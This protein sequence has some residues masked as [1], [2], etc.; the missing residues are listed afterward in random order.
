MKGIWSAIGRLAVVAAL[1][2]GI[3]VPAIRA[4]VP[5]GFSYQGIL[6]DNGTPITSGNVTMV[7]VLMDVN[8]APLYTET[9]QNV[10]VTNGIFNVVI[11]GT[12][13]P[14]PSTMTFDEQYL[15]QVEVE[16]SNG[17][18]TFPPTPLW[19]APFALN[20]GTVGGI[21]ASLVPT[22][23]KLFPV[24]IGSGY[25]GT[26]R[27]DPAFLPPGAIGS[28]LAIGGGTMFGNIAMG[29]NSITGANGISASVFTGGTGSFTTLSASSGINLT[30][31]TLSTGGTARLDNSGN[32]TNITSLH[33]TGPI[34]GAT[35]ISSSGNITFSSLGNGVVH[36]TGGTGLLAST[37]VVNA[38]IANGTIDLTAKVT[39]VL[40]V[41]NGG[42]GVSKVSGNVVFASPANGSVGPPAFR[43]LVPADLPS[44]SGLYLPTAGGTMTGSI[45]MTGN[46]ISGAGTITGTTVNANAFNGGSGS[47]TT[48]VS[49]S[50]T[51]LGPTS[52][53]SIN[54]T[55]IGLNQP[56]AADFTSIGATTLGTGAFTTLFATSAVSGGTVLGVTNS[57][58]G[59]G[60]ST[61]TGAAI[62]VTGSG[63]GNTYTGI[64]LN[65]S[66][67]A[68][69]A[70]D[71]VGTSANWRVTSAGAGT[72][73]SMSLATPL[74]VS[75][76][77]T[78]VTSTSQNFVFAGP[79]TGNGAPTWR[80]L[81]VGDLPSLNGT[82]LPISGGTM[83]GPINMSGNAITNGGPIT[84]TAITGTTVTGGS[85]AATNTTNQ[86]V[87]GTAKTITISS[88]SPSAS[89]TYTLPDAGS[90]ASFILS[91][92]P[93]GQTIGGG[94][95][96]NGGLTLGTPLAV[97]QGGTGLTSTSQNFVFAGPMS[98]SGAPTWRALTA[99]DLPNLS[100]SYLPI[101]G[102]TM[103]GAINM[104]T[105]N[106]TNA[107]TI[108]G[109]AITGTSI[110]GTSFNGGSGSFTT[111][112]ATNTTN[113]LV[114]G[115]TK[116][117]TISSTTPS[118]SET[119]TLP[120]AGGAASFILSTSPASQT[121]GGGLTVNGGLTLG[122]PL[123]VAQGGTGLTSTSQNFVFAGP[124]TGSGAP[125]WR[126]LTAGDLPNLS[127]SY[128]PIS[129]GTMA[130]AINMG[131]NNI[132]NAGTIT[133][134]A[135]TGTSITGTS[136][137]G[138]TGSF[139]TLAATNTT[140]QLV[141]GTAKTITISSTTPLAS[142]TYTLP[143]AGGAASFILSTSPAGQTIGGG[144]TVNGGLT[145][146][147]PLAVAQGGTGLTSTS[148]NFVFAGPT[149]GSGAPTW[150]ALTAGDLP[151][152]SG[153]YLPISGGTMAG[154]INMG[155]NN[156]TNAGTITGTAITGTSITG[157]SFNGGTGSFTTLTSSSTTTLGPTT[158]T[159]LNNTPIGVATPAAANFTS[160]GATTPGTASFSTVLVAPGAV[161]STSVTVKQTS[162]SPSNVPVFVVQNPTGTTTFL[163]VNSSGQTNIGDNTAAGTLVMH[164][165]TGATPPQTQLTS[166]ETS[167]T[168]NI[169]FPDASG[170]VA[171]QG[172]VGVRVSDATTTPDFSASS[173]SFFESTNSGNVTIKIPSPTDG[174]MIYLVWNR[175]ATS[176]AITVP[177][178]ST[179]LT[180]PSFIPPKLT[181]GATL[182][183]NGTNWY[184]VG[185]Y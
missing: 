182:V 162:A 39:G 83:S 115:T 50:I 98:G 134:T 105:N 132:T 111:L 149:T 151:N 90:A 9:L 61:Q 159:S 68:G 3:A 58:N 168:R 164:H 127:G 137:N 6:E 54:N 158:A 146:G 180:G 36:A 152:L 128:L 48:L 175:A 43:P 104:G 82:Y 65:V 108:T 184:V 92:S 136:F 75:S 8:N 113:Q 129:G 85:L 30:G 103:A 63:A 32:L 95:T 139:T 140:N 53:T 130:G 46:N 66:A 142:E 60:S 1:V 169:A 183:G 47:F 13:S 89:E 138:G 27:I 124:T 59:N 33:M 109:T 81:T 171:L 5:S 64:T 14:F 101:S 106:I 80:A 147:T 7:V 167:T 150:R 2:L 126:A 22:S 79:V 135:I 166:S 116:T 19:S 12:A 185:I 163:S 11:G 52:A 99:G 16:T 42:T 121:I 49:T 38:N 62:S 178:G 91:T 148:Q 18:K 94:L 145:L 31:G 21:G 114:L 67:A 181:Q 24:P 157:T 26:A 35:G 76:G 165:A 160:I 133:G 93:A 86:L 117:I 25:T 177:G 34:S 172:S 122:T 176:I 74:A 154:A 119:Y 179:I 87:L 153:S 72:F 118:A 144:L 29:N 174:R 41:A 143:D 45:A 17:T 73:N 170:T 107:G 77:G 141:L 97:A 88:T 156:I 173:A 102:G 120:D 69:T 71:I 20:A 51:E 57:S 78:G 44:F 125:T 4:Q 10:I 110:T 15:M 55:P 28:W 84:G 70:N 96:V 56:A 123:A 40:P 37:P 161:N 112:A 100:G 23:G 155:T 131:T